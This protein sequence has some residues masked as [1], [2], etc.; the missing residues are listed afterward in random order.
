MS[1]TPSRLGYV[2]VTFRP[3]GRPYAGLV[4]DR[5]AEA[6]QA[7][8]AMSLRDGEHVIAEVTRLDD[9]PETAL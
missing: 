4:Y 9:T 2:V 6:G 7:R 5:P 1:N 3:P 8:R